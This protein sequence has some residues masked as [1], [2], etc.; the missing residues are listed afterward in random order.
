MVAL[1]I[2][3]ILTASLGVGR[4]SGHRM[5]GVISGD[6]ERLCQED[7]SVPRAWCLGWRRAWRQK[8]GR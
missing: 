2:R 5:I 3:R 1:L 6:D 4:V 8:A 7:V